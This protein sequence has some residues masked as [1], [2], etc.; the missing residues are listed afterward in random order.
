LTNETQLKLFNKIKLAICDTV[1]YH[2]VGK[3]A[4][5]V[6]T[7]FIDWKGASVSVFITEDGRLTDGGQ[8]LSQLKSLRVIEDFNNWD[9]KFDFFQRSR[10]QQLRGNL[11]PLDIDSVSDILSYIQ[12]ITRLPNF[13]EPKPIYATSD[14]FPIIARDVALDA[15]IN[16][17]PYDEFDKREKWA[18]KFIKARNIPLNGF[19]IESDMSPSKYYRLIKIISHATSSMSDRKQHVS[20]KVLD[21]LLWKRDEPDVELY[22]IVDD[23]DAYPKESKS[24][25]REESEEIIQIKSDRSGARLAE[26]LTE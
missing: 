10:I 14:K 16:I 7:P 21:S 15:L 22:V 25:L 2:E 17:A 8:I 20:A 1:Q 9:F 5:E 23:V 13:F 4:I 3:N 19:H 11:E 12:G 24:L 18:T 6:V 26:I